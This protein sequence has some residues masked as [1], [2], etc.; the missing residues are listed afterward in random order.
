HPISKTGLAKRLLGVI[1]IAWRQLPQSLL[2][3]HRADQK[4]KQPIADVA[5]AALARDRAECVYRDGDAGEDEQP[6]YPSGPGGL[7]QEFDDVRNRIGVHRP[8]LIAF[9]HPQ[10]TISLRPR[11]DPPRAESPKS[12]PGRTSQLHPPLLRQRPPAAHRARWRQ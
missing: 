5:G 4:A 7:Q 9:S 2:P 6:E 10:T 1:G 3:P 11:S 8:N 12:P